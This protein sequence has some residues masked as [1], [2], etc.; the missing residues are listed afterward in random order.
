[1]SKVAIDAANVIAHQPGGLTR[2]LMGASA[3]AQEAHQKDICDK[4]I[5]LHSKTHTT[6][7]AYDNAVMLA[8]YV[9]FFALWAGV[10]ESITLTWRLV[11]V[12][13]MAISLMC[14][15]GWQVLQMLTRQ[16]YEFKCTAILKSVDDPARFNADW[17]KASQDYEIAGARL[18]RFWPILF[19]P[20]VVLGF[21]AAGT[22]G[23][24]ALAI[25]LGWPQL[26]G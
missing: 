14:Y 25:V 13:L 22:L 5:E 10:D 12:C 21:A 9:A 26:T 7:A 8:G 20:S 3:A 18:M 17:V 24:N 15:M 11:T 2:T 19:L 1:M 23:Y 6:A 4:L 16:F